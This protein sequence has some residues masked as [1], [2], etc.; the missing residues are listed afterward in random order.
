MRRRE[1]M[2]LVGGASAAWPL[3]LYAQQ[4]DRV[5]RIG[6]FH[7]NGENDGTNKADVAAFRE[8]L[9]KRGWTEGHN[10]R[11]DY[12][13][14]DAD[15][16]RMRAHATELVDLSLDVIL[17]IGGTMLAALLRQTHTVPIVFALVS[18]PVGAGFV[19]NLARPG[20]NV[21]GFSHYEYS[22]ASKWLEMLKEIAPEITRVA[23]IVTPGVPAGPGLL[24]EIETK[25]PSIGVRP[26]A[27]TRDT[28]LDRAIEAFAAKSKAGLVLLP[29]P[30][31]LMQQKQSVAL[32]TRHQLPAVYPFRFHVLLGGLVSYTVNVADLYR[33]AAG[34]VDR[35]L[36]GEKPGDLPV[37][38]PT[39]FEL[40]INLKTAKALGVTIPQSLLLR[41]DEVIE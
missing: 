41:A 6:V 29:A 38:Q 31:T 9:W 39:K 34:Y 32:A 12:R 24:H 17:A 21:T 23:V 15:A 30:E 19:S 22:V 28:S 11:I 36:R 18:D 7:G 8:E 33:R 3:A 20:G 27:F 14:A 13:W 35:I 16:E 10:V 5:R 1:F 25:A 37:Q 40:V 2:V 4:P 26:T